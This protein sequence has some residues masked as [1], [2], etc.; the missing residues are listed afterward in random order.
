LEGGQEGGFGVARRRGQ[1]REGDDEGAFGE[2]G[3]ARP[4]LGDGEQH[5]APDVLL[6][7]FGGGAGSL[8]E[9]GTETGGEAA[10][11]ISERQ[12]EGGNV[13]EGEDP[14]VAG[15][16]EKVA[17][18][19]RDGGEGSRA[20]INEGAEDAGGEGLAGARGALEDQER[21]RSKGAE[22]GEEPGEAA[23]P[24]CAGRE[25]EAG[26]EGIQS[27]GH[28]WRAGV[29][30]SAVEDAGSGRDMVEREVRRRTPGPA[31]VFQPSGEISTN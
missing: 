15:E 12:G 5:G 22:G 19:G 28:G 4:T 11:G 20:G 8:A 17:D 18:G 26:A 25:V 1:G 10:E 9:G 23:E 31:V 2:V 13:V 6:E 24:G 29:G 27:R 3:G 30:G 16:G 7:R 21:K 14:V